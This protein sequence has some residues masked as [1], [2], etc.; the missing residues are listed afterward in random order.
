MECRH[1]R[2][3]PTMDNKDHYRDHDRQYRGENPQRMVKW[4]KRI[5]IK[6]S[7]DTGV[8]IFLFAGKK[9][10]KEKVKWKGKG[11]EKGVKG[12]K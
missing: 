5:G 1:T 6:G 2:H 10:G 12:R 9:K 4:Y 3:Q 8:Y 7:T 11:K